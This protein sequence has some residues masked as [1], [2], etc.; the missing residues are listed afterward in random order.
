M[1]LLDVSPC[2]HCTAVVG[3]VSGGHLLKA[4]AG[5]HSV[6]GAGFVWVYGCEFWVRRQARHG[7]WRGKVGEG[8]GRRRKEGEGG[9]RRGRR[10][11]LEKGE[12][13]PPARAPR[14]LRLLPMPCTRTLR[15]PARRAH[16]VSGGRGGQERC[17]GRGTSKDVGKWEEECQRRA[18]ESGTPPPYRLDCSLPFP[19]FT[20]HHIPSRNIPPAR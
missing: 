15:V 20:P 5:M 4:F 9:G 3:Y 1:R 14:L 8:G 16:T 17:R 13:Q 7:G 2:L 19:S 18:E 12:A 11:V 10:G 6:M